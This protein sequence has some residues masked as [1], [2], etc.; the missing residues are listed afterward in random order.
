LVLS[1][2]DANTIEY[3]RAPL[4]KSI[5]FDYGGMREFAIINSR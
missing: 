5:G 1:G 2:Y 3:D 4:G